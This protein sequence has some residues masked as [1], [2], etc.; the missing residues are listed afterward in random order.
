MAGGP[1]PVAAGNEASWTVGVSDMAPAA[2]QLTYTLGGS[3]SVVPGSVHTAPGWTAT[4]SGA[5]AGS[6]ALLGDSLS[7]P[8]A[9]PASTVSQSVG[10]D[11]FVPILV[12]DRV[13]AIYHLTIPSMVS[14]IDRRTNR[15]CPGYPIPIGVGAS[16]VPG[17]AV[18]IGTRFYQRVST[19]QSYDQSASGALFCW[20]TA[21]AQPCGLMIVARSHRTTNMEGSAPVW[22]AGSSGSRWTTASCTASTRPRT[23]RVE[24]WTPA[25]T[26]TERRST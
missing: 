20:D 9:K 2:P 25:W 23:R 7:V 21:T 18:V 19:A 4:A 24:A 5:D 3:H 26:P 8:V 13:Y 12:G 14:C 22:S 11:G 1:D 16:G 17:P 6:G 10:G 15:L